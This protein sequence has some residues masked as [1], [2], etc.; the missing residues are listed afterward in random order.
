ME[1]IINDDCIFCKLANGVI[2]T[3]TVFEDDDY[4]VI[5]DAAPANLGHCLVLPKTHAENVFELGEDW[6]AGAHALAKRVA[7][8]VKKATNCDGINILQ[9]NGTAAE[10]SV[11]HYH[12]HIIPRLE[13]DDVTIKF[14]SFKTDE[15]A[16]ILQSIKESM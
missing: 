5:L 7:L 1:K 12:V 16:S 14:G 9:N 10:Q 3:N 8:A 2:P 13:S 6:V 15:P 11:M 4:R